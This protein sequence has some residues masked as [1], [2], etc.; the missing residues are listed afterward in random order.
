MLILPFRD[1]KGVID[2]SYSLRMC[3]VTRST[4]EALAGAYEVPSGG[5]IEIYNNTFI[6][7]TS[8]RCSKQ[9]SL[10]PCKI[11]NVSLNLMF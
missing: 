8:G 6:I 9:S 10:P 2:T 7:F 5:I 1:E 4:A 11:I 3:R